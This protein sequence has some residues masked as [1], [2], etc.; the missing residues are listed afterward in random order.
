MYSYSQ[1][2]DRGKPGAPYQYNNLSGQES[3]RVEI[4]WRPPAYLEEEEY[5]YEV[6]YKEVNG[7]KWQRLETKSQDPKAVVTNLRAG[8][9]Y[10]FKVRVVYDDDEGPYGP[11]SEE[12]RT[13]QSPALSIRQRSEALLGREG[14]MQTPQRFALSLTEIDAARSDEGKIRGFCIGD[15]TPEK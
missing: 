2:E 11:E 13:I 10:V 9:G 5:S 1:Q 4:C 7:K 12:I 8:T 3:D 14:N 6:R 15:F